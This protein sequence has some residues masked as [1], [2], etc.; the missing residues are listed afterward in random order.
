MKF[1]KS[2]KNASKMKRKFRQ[3]LKKL[4]KTKKVFMKKNH[5]KNCLFNIGKLKP[6]Q[7][8]Y[9]LA[10]NFN[11][12][13]EQI[14]KMTSFFLDKN[15]LIPYHEIIHIIEKFDSKEDESIKKPECILLT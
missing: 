4:I 7:F 6:I 14:E 15:G 1:L 10:E 9:I 11:L 13:N 3:F 5:W 2:R 12:E 8:K